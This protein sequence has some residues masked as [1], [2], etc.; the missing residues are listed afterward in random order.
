MGSFVGIVA[1]A[2][3]LIMVLVWL[4]IYLL[5]RRPPNKKGLRG[6]DDELQQVSSTPPESPRR[7]SEARVSESHEAARENTE[8]T[9]SRASEETEV[10]RKVPVRGREAEETAS[11][12]PGG[13]YSEDVKVGDVEV[14]S[15]RN[16]ESTHG[17]GKVFERR[18]LPFVLS[19]SSVPLFEGEA[20]LKCFY[21]LMEDPGVVGWMAFHDEILGASDRIYEDGF[22]DAL[23]GY[24]RTVSKLQKEVGLSHVV[25]TSIV[26]EE[27]MVW[28]LTGREDSWFAL[29]LDRDV[30]VHRLVHQLL[31][32]V[33]GAHSEQTSP[34]P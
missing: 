2:L 28:F 17:S 24:R 18:A 10:Y 25:E 1:I 33:L 27:G 30:D 3:I 6:G 16:N 31:A 34:Y 12:R 14:L 9:K 7:R 5:R 15:A 23:R 26:G 4:N 21:Q 8:F 13:T 20:W 11:Q 22:V 32:D 29:F 19:R